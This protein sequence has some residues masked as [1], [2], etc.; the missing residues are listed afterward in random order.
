MGHTEDVLKTC[1]QQN[2]NPTWYI[3][4]QGP[5]LSPVGT[6]KYTCDQLVCSIPKGIC[7]VI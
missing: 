2:V 5:K 3:T 1:V 4:Y 6:L 7:E